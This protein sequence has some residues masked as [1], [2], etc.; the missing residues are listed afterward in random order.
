MLVF[1]I[2]CLCSQGFKPTVGAGGV[3][4][5]N[6]RTEAAS[7]WCCCGSEMVVGVMV[8]LVDMLLSW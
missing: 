8:V 7:G 5:V 4:G 6:E 1:W 2:L 3:D